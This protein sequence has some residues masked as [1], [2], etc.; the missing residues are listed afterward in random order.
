MLLWYVKL[1]QH[2][3]M[4]PDRFLYFRMRT[5]VAPLASVITKLLLNLEI[6]P[7]SENKISWSIHCLFK[8][9]IVSHRLIVWPKTRNV[10]STNLKLFD[11]SK[12][13]TKTYH[14]TNR[15]LSWHSCWIVKKDS[16]IWSTGLFSTLRY[17][18]VEQMLLCLRFFN[19]KVQCWRTIWITFCEGT[20]LLGKEIELWSATECRFSIF[21]RC[22][23]S[24]KCFK[25]SEK[26]R[27][28]PNSSIV[29]YMVFFWIC[30]HS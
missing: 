12:K 24:W 3:N 5:Y 29:R 11:C 19:S 4:I 13:Q 9:N 16:D 17:Y 6:F 25:R 2:L 14:K 23:G 28:S 20:A 1:L 8:P 21:C 18:D 15:N 10:I 22:W 27:S 30:I 7:I 26:W